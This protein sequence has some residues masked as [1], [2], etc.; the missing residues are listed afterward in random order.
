[1]E[2]K[3]QPRVEDVISVL[4]FKLLMKSIVDHHAKIRIK[5]L[6]DGGSWTINF[7][8]VVM[9]TDKGMILSDEENNKILSISLTNGIVQFIIDEQFDSYLPNLA[10]AVQ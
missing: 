7:F 5:Y 6:P 9:V 10:Y 8:N 3:D 1:M 4:E 2:I